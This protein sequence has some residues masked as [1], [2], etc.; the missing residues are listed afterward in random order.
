[1][2]LLRYQSQ[3]TA[4]TVTPSMCGETDAVLLRSSPYYNSL[5]CVKTVDVIMSI[6]SL[7]KPLG[8]CSCDSGKLIVTD[9]CYLN[10]SEALGSAAVSFNTEIGDGEFAVYEQRDRRGRLKR[11][12]IEID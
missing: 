6:L 3:E 11:I 4:K 9:P 7:S 1:M 5:T 10:S 2:E 8:I 12:V